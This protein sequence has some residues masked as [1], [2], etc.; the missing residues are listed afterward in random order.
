V[1]AEGMDIA[2]M[3]SSIPTAKTYSINI[4]IMFAMFNMV[5]TEFVDIFMV[6]LHIKF[7]CLDSMVY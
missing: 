5:L 7:T 4:I 2:S 1:S 6:Y 3:Y